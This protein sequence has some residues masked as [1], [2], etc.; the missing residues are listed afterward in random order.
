M[1]D[2]RKS[3]ISAM[4]TPNSELF[5]KLKLYVWNLFPFDF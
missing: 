4:K 1:Y 5:D 2:I 3:E